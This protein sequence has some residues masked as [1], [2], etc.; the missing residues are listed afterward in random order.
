MTLLGVN[1]DHVAT[2]R[3]ARGSSFPDPVEAALICQEAGADSIVAHLREDRRHIQDRDVL[4]LKGNL[5]VK[6]NLELSID[7]TVLRT[8]YRVQPG[9]VTF[10][11]E[12]RQERTTESGLDV[13]GLR[14]KLKA[15]LPAL[16]KRKISVSLFVDPDPKQIAAA[17]E[18]GAAAVEIHTGEYANAKG[19]KQA[20][21][22]IR[23]IEQAIQYSNSLGLVTHVGHGL[24]Y[25]NVRKVAELEGI[26]EFNIGY[27]IITK[28]LYVGLGNAVREMK[29]L[30]RAREI[31]VSHS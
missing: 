23:K 9:G 11:P 25:E 29:S 19:V 5:S 2:L 7:P 16:R 28:A 31:E 8:A 18:L 3:Q 30:I 20:E 1:V 13:I 15:I 4:R 26:C 21:R 22:C 24:D 14:K 17:R 10:V 27:A 12:R 6:L